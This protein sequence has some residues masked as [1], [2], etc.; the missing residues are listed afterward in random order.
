[1]ENMEEKLADIQTRLSNLKKDVTCIL[2]WV[3]HIREVARE[4]PVPPTEDEY[5]ECPIC[6]C[7][8]DEIDKKEGRC[9]NCGQRLKWGE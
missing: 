2:T 4:I 6:M 3:M 9:Q 5:P 1:M 7:D 8:V